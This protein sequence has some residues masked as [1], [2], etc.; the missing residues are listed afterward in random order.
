MGFFF[1]L[2][3]FDDAVGRAYGAYRDIDLFRDNLL[4]ALIESLTWREMLFDPPKTKD[5]ISPSARE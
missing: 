3:R 2:R 4:I 1:A 5:L